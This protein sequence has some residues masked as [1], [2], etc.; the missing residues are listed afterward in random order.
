MRH[1]EGDIEEAEVRGTLPNCRI[2]WQHSPARELQASAGGTLTTQAAAWRDCTVE[3]A[4]SIYQ[5]EGCRLVP[6]GLHTCSSLERLHSGSMWTFL[7][8]LVFLYYP[9]LCFL[10]L[11]LLPSLEPQAG[12]QGYPRTHILVLAVTR[13]GAW[14]TLCFAPPSLWGGSWGCGDI[15]CCRVE[16]RGT[17]PHRKENQ[18]TLSL[19]SSKF[20]NN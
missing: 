8:S 12:P 2:C 7:E 16:N 14:A 17:S 9:N 19:A 4:D 6:G 15:L 18:G 5:L 10:E 3:S 11:C 20:L 13:K 1:A